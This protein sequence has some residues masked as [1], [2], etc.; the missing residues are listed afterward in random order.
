MEQALVFASIIVGVAVSD[1]VMSLNRLLV[2][3]HRVK[4]DWAPLILALLVLMTN[5]QLWWSVASWRQST[6]TIGAFL[7]MSFLLILLALL[8][9]GSLPGEGEVDGEGEFD[10][11]DYYERNARY[12]WT[13]FTIAVSWSLGMG[14]AEHFGRGSAMWQLSHRVIELVPLAMMISLIFVRARWWL[15]ICLAVLSLGP[16]NWLSLSLG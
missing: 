13:L 12:L 16:L 1:Q 15:A 4:W 9:A 7:P 14:I 10:L 8:S 3:R 5:M 6:I 11:R 2:A